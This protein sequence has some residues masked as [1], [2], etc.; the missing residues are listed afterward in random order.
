MVYRENLSFTITFLS[1]PGSNCISGFDAAFSTG[2]TTRGNPT[3]TTRY[4]LSGGAVTG[5]ISAS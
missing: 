1:R 5:S 2:Y 4:L 3:G